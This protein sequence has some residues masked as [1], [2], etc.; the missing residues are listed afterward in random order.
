MIRIVARGETTAHRAAKWKRNFAIRAVKT[1]GVS[2]LFPLSRPRLDRVT[3]PSAY[4]KAEKSW[5]LAVY[6]Q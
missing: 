1:H 4:Q 5:Q 3:F 6:D 2:Y